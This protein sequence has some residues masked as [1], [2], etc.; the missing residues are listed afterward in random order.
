M[1]KVKKQRTLN[2]IKGIIKGK[3]SKGITTDEFSDNIADN[4]ADSFAKNFEEVMKNEL[5]KKIGDG[6]KEENGKI[7]R[8]ENLFYFRSIVTEES[9]SIL[10]D[11]IDEYNRE[12]DEI[13]NTLSS[14]YCFRKPIYLFITSQ[15]GDMYHGFRAY[16]HIK[17]SE[18][19]IYTVACAY[20]IS[21]GSLM[22]M[23]GKKRFMT[24]NSHILIHQLSNYYGNNGIE[25]KTF[26][27]S[28]DDLYNDMNHMNKI[29]KIY[30]TSTRYAYSPVP[31]KNILTKKILEEHMSHD[32]FWTYDTCFK[33]GIVDKLYTNHKEREID[34]QN[35]FFN[36]TQLEIKQPRIKYSEKDFEPSNDIIEKVKS[37]RNNYQN[38]L[39]EIVS[40]QLKNRKFVMEDEEDLD[41][42]V[43]DKFVSESKAK[44]NKRKSKKRSRS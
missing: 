8:K 26:L 39:M 16:D 32:I 21:A 7:F 15:G 44:T 29:Y 5:V 31:K 27:Q 41:E 24:E 10:V 1:Y 17:N 43:E 35:L 6:S 18:T 34:D 22:F 11:M 13:Q 9:I 3:L 30:L 14:N 25:K 4:I 19:P 42:L 2:G 33:Y 37:N 20:A 28:I 40:S 38:E 36:K 23:A 12:Q